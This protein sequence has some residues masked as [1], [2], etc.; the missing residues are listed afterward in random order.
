MPYL[1]LGQVQK[2]IFPTGPM[3]GNKWQDWS[4][5][6]APHGKAGQI[7]QRPPIA[8]IRDEW[9]WPAFT[10]SANCESGHRQT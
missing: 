1:Y 4:F 2:G 3:D 8:V 5:L 6:E 9:E 7:E 10:R